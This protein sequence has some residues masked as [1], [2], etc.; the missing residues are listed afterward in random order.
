MSF[1][2]IGKTPFIIAEI[3]HN[4]QGKIEIAFEMIKQAKLCGAN[5]VKFQK[6]S[7]KQLYTK[8]FYSE[9]YDHKNSYG[10]TN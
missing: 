9:K 1:D 7:N 6:R 4:H 8:K 10:K 3:G 5:A 2:R